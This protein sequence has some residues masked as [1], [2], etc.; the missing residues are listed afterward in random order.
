MRKQ[1]NNNLYRSCKD[2][3]PKPNSVRERGLEPP[4]IAPLVPKTNAATNYAT[5]ALL[6][7]IFTSNKKDIST[8]NSFLK[9]KSILRLGRGSNPC[10][11]VLQTAALPLRHPA[12]SYSLIQTFFQ[13]QV[14]NPLSVFFAFVYF[15]INKGNHPK[16]HFFLQLVLYSTSHPFTKIQRRL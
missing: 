8:S 13:K 12:N 1:N 7:L 10:M 3:L 11:A 15:N 14:M 4:R 2:Q 9:Y 5:W 16:I 6:L